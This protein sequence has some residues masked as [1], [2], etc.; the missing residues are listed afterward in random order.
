MQNENIETTK[1]ESTTEVTAQEQ[2]RPLPRVA[3]RQR[4]EETDTGW[5]IQVE[6]P[7]VAPD[8][9]QLEVVQR[10]LQLEAS[11]A[12]G[13]AQEDAKPLHQEYRRAAF[14]QSW[15]LPARVD[16]DSIATNYRHGLLTIELPYRAPERRKIEV[17]GA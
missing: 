9:L 4:V 2:V 10:V 17:H 7:G 8:D 3:P 13:S 12:E 15:R 6:L 11:P 16:L 1:T 5:R 14:A